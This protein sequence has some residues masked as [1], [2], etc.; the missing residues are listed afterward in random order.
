MSRPCMYDPFEEC[1]YNCIGCIRNM[2][3]EEP[4]YDSYD[5]RRD[6]EN[7]FFGFDDEE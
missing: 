5:D 6:D 3:Y 2:D 7:Y 4:E 1:S